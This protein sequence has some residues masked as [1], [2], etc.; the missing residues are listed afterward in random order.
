MP[1]EVFLSV[2]LSVVLFMS[3]VMAASYVCECDSLHKFN[4]KAST[5]ATAL[6]HDSENSACAIYMKLK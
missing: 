2:L 5:V 6:F 1:F 4:V 3:H